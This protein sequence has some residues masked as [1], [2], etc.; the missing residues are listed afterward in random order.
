VF[1]A[2]NKKA[3]LLA[4]NTGTETRL[5]YEK[6]ANAENQLK[7]QCIPTPVLSVSGF[8]GI[9]SA[10]TFMIKAPRAILNEGSLFWPKIR[11]V[12]FIK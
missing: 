11:T 8:A 1:H 5:M 2:L 3:L 7:S 4:G 9:I 6:T 10:L 12:I